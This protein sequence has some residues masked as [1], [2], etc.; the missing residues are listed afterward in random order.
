MRRIV[1]GKIKDILKYSAS[2]LSQREIAAAAGSSLGTV[3]TVLAKIKE[4]GIKDPLALKE[5]ELGA[6]C[7]SDTEDSFRRAA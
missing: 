1:M 6:H 7:L 3:N 5:H 2:G 4:A